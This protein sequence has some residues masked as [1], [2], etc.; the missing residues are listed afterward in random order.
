MSQVFTAQRDSRLV[1]AYSPARNT[2]LAG[3]RGL[4]GQAGP[5]GGSSFNRLSAAPVSALIVVWEDEHGAVRPLDSHDSQHADLIAGI[6][7]TA[8]AAGQEVTV[9]RLGPLDA[10]GLNLQPGRVWLGRNG[11][12]TQTPPE[13]G[14]DTLLGYAT[15]EQRLYIDI[16]ETI[17]LED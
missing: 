9:Q 4:P 3:V 2:V 7:T 5:A 14:F 13:D 17:Q 16:S 12:L 1:R 6:T 15:A 10:S 11:A 8:A